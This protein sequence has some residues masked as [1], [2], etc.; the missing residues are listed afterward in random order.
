[1]WGSPRHAHRRR[2]AT[3]LVWTSLFSISAPLLPHLGSQGKLATT[4]RLVR[5]PGVQCVLIAA[6]GKQVSLCVFRS[7]SAPC[8]H[9]GKMR[10]RWMCCPGPSSP[11]ASSLVY[12]L[13][14]WGVAWLPD[15]LCR[16]HCPQMSCPWLLRGPV[17]GNG[18]ATPWPTMCSQTHASC[19][20]EVLVGPPGPPQDS[21]S[22]RS[23]EGW[24]HPY[25]KIT[26]T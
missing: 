17:S 12:V 24:G 18:G 19:G 8:S 4:D 3:V 13:L 2:G 7:G 5:G 22:L 11:A 15:S 26:G 23:L 14:T 21:G 1:M 6:Y 10:P 9:P 25:T 16:R 20:P